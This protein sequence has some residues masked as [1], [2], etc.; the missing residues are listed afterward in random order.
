M[1]GHN[2]WSKIKNQKEITDA[3]KGLLYTEHVKK[4]TQ[5]VREGKNLAA[6]LEKAKSANVPKDIIDRAIE[7]A[8]KRGKEGKDVIFEAFG[9]EGKYQLIILAKT[10]NNNRTSGQLRN[11]L[12]KHGGKLGELGS[13]NYLFEKV[14]VILIKKTP[15]AENAILASKALDFYEAD[16]GYE[17]KTSPDS[18][19]SVM[20]CLEAN[21]AEILNFSLGYLPL[22]TVTLTAEE[23]EL[24]IHLEKA[25]RA[26]AE[27]TEI[28]A[29]FAI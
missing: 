2:K 22:Q 12:E 13:V 23:K 20:D 16:E 24:F 3:R 17:V 9:P 19:S 15:A 18:L 4:I 21:G 14:G 7:N 1:S 5:A 26:I 27:V 6:T 11:V 29:N 25:I 10:E 28:Y 8:Q